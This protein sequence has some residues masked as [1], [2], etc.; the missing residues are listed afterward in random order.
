MVFNHPVTGEEVFLHREPEGKAFEI[1][2]Q[3]DW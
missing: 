2:D 3:M 1:M